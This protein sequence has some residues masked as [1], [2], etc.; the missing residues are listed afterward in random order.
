MFLGDIQHLTKIRNVRSN[1]GGKAIIQEVNQKWNSLC[2]IINKKR[3]EN[4]MQLD[5][6]KNQ[7]CNDIPETNIILGERLSHD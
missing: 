2:N 3:G 4:I 6:F 5:G 7:L 1:E